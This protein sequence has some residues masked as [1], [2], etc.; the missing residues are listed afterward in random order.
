MKLAFIFLYLIFSLHVES[1]VEKCHKNMVAIQNNLTLS[2]SILKVHCVSKDDDLGDH[3]LRFQDVAY[4]F[5]FHD[6]L[7]ITRFKCILWKGANLEYHQ[8]FTAYQGG[9]YLKCGKF[10]S[11][12]ARDDGIYFSRNREPMKLMYIWDKY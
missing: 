1:N 3:F 2:R 10:N 8:N 12:E 5:S 6:S 4:N 11:W 9:A 7:L